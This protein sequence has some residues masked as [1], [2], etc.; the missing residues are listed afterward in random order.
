MQYRT[1][2]FRIAGFFC[3]GVGFSTALIP[4]VPTVPFFIMAAFFL[5]RSSPEWHRWIRLNKQFGKTVRAWEDHGVL[6]W[7]IKLFTGACIISAMIAP[8][9]L[10]NTPIIFRVLWFI[11]LVVALLYLVSR[12]SS[13]K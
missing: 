10:N 3:L 9:Y 4:L 1:I 13:I 11:I 6:D 8:M 7:K 12:P 5:S 2:F